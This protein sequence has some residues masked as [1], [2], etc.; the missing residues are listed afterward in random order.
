MTCNTSCP[1]PICNQMINGTLSHELRIHR[2]ATTTAVCDNYGK[3]LTG[4]I[5]GD[6]IC[7]GYRVIFGDER[8]GGGGRDDAQAPHIDAIFRV[9]IGTPVTNLDRVELLSAY[10]RAITPT[11]WY[12]VVRPPDVGLTVT[13][14]FARLI[15][16][17]D[18][19]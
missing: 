9:P 10:G 6:E 11:Q 3:P 4:W 19:P 18:T 8:V 15:N 7:G 17:G 13:R 2:R 14:L 1:P 16:D 12:E 5:A